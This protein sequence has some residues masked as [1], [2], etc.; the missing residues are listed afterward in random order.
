[1]KKLLVM[2]LVL[3]CLCIAAS[4]LA[5]SGTLVNAPSKMMTPEMQYKLG[6]ER[7]TAQKHVG[8]LTA[9]EFRLK[10]LI[11]HYR[12]GQNLSPED[13]DFLLQYFP[14]PTRAADSS[15]RNPLDQG[16]DNCGSATVIGGIPFA[17]TGTT[18]GY[19]NDYDESC[20][21]TGS[22]SPDVAYSFTP[23]ADVLVNISLCTNSAYDTKVYVYQ[24]SCPGTLIACNDDY[25]S[26]PLFSSYVSFLGCVTL[27]AGNSYYIIVD[28]Y[29]GDL[30]D[31]TLDVT[32]CVPPPIGRCCYQGSCYD[33]IDIA[34]CASI[35]GVPGSVG[36]TCASE[37][38]PPPEIGRCCYQ[39]VCYEGID[40]AYCASIGGVPGSVGSTCT[41]EPCPPPPPPPG[42]LR[43]ITVPVPCNL[44]V[45]I[46][47]DCRGDLY[48]TDFCPPFNLYQMDAFGALISATPILDAAGAAHQI[49]EIGWDEGRQVF[50]GGEEGSHGIYTLDR[51]GLATFQFTGMGGLSITDG[52]DYD[53]TDGTIWHSTDVSADIAHFDVTGLLLGTLTLYDENGNPEG[54][55]SGVEMGANNTIFAGNSPIDDVRRCNKSTGAFVS[56]FDAGQV[57]C[58]GMECDAI[59]F[60]PQVALWVKDAYNNTVTAFEIDAGTCVCAQL[61]DTC[62]F[63]YQEIDDGDLA[64]CNYPTFHANPGHGLSGVAWLGAGITGEPAPNTL[65]L[66][67]ADDGV[68][69]IGLP[70]TP[71]TPVAVTVTVTGGP[72][73][74]LFENCGGHLYLNGWKDGNLDGDFCDEL[75]GPPPLPTASEWL[76]HDVL[77]TP[78]VFAFTFIDPGVFDLGAYDGVFRWRLTSTPVGRHGFGLMVAGACVWNCPATFGLDYL[79][80]VEDYIIPDAQLQVE[81]SNFDAIS[82]DNSVTLRWTT[83]SESNN[84]HFEI[85]RGGSLIHS[86]PSSGNTS[87]GHSYEWVDSDVENGRTYGYS[88][89][90]VDVN[91]TREELATTNATP[92]ANA[93]VVTEYAL[94]QNFPNPFNPSTTIT[95]DLVESGN[96]TLQV[97][98][99]MGQEVATLVNGNLSSGRHTL[100][101]SAEGL[102]S[103]L[104]LY[105]LD[106]N[107]FSSQKKMLLMK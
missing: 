67:P 89:V 23:A 52:I 3:T 41:S 30:G 39:D 15:P 4:V 90:A 69:Y 44:G 62:L 66:D 78:G 42:A 11:N 45:S 65:N 48:Y 60:A 75:C 49:D 56:R 77:V 71:C 96:V 57:R 83:A 29:A 12:M 51:A 86:V 33:G 34:Y 74:P 35:G 91:G 20:P 31:Y 22:T 99:L 8:T 98:N 73:Y 87:S 40:V 93:V 82:G 105:K 102:P 61:P 32:E 53:G 81:L 21:Y 88:L 7:V 63:P 107:G 47:A 50:W 72:V 14:N 54:T 9:D 103:G 37:P 2:C 68:A 24:G 92:N 18:S 27:L 106:A 25:C 58:E 101:F 64:A 17:D 79:G 85:T 59:N 6:L 104:Y 80:E 19:T 84:D 5:E 43:V 28:G 70:W 26:S 95:F 100:N 46:S 1:M 38:C 97:F 10:E 13:M 36:S 55:I 76:V 94:H 16:G